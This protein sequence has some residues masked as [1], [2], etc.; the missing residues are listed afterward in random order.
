MFSCSCVE[1]MLSNQPRSLWASVMSGL[2]C[3]TLDCSSETLFPP[4][5]S[6]IRPFL[7]A[8]TGWRLPSNSSA[9]LPQRVS[10]TWNR[11]VN[12]VQTN[13]LHKAKTNVPDS[14]WCTENLSET[15]RVLFQNKFEKLVHLIGFIIRIYHDAWSSECQIHN[16]S[17]HKISHTC[18]VVSN[19]F[20]IKLKSN[21]WYTRYSTKEWRE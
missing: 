11:K 15:C 5:Y 8:K 21:Y 1:P 7:T 2:T 20:L 6:L 16:L 12:N 4:P 14:W 10:V 13:R 19:L 9:W 17:P 18:P 3:K